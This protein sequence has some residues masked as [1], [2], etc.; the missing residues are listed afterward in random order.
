MNIEIASIREFIIKKARIIWTKGSSWLLPKVKALYAK[1]PKK[2]W[3]AGILLLAYL[4]CLPSPLFKEPTC[5]V[6]E[7]KNGNLLGARIAA[8]GQWRFPYSENIPEKYVQCLVEFED[9]RFYY[10]PG[11]D[12]V[13][14][15]R[16]V[17]QNIRNRK[18]V[19]GGSTI[20]MQVMRMSRKAQSRSL[21]QKLIEAVLA[22]RLEL[23]H[24]KKEIMALYASN[25]PYGG[26]VVGLEAASWRYFGKNPK[27][28]S[29]AEAATLAVLPNSPALIHPGR[30]RESLALK[31]NRLLKRLYDHHKIDKT[32]YSLAIEEPLP[33]QPLPLPRLAPHLLD[34]AYEEYF[35]SEKGKITRLRTTIDPFLQNQVN[36]ILQNHLEHLSGNGI[37]NLAAIVMDVETGNV[38]AYVGNVP[39]AG[40]EHGEDVDVIRAARSTGSI[41]KPFLFSWMLQEGAILP[42]SLVSDIPTELSGYRPENYKETY[43]GAIPARRALSRSLNIPFVRL[44][45]QF[46]LEKFHYR[47]KKVGFSTINKP[48]SYYG[49]P[50][51][52]GGAEATLWDI[53]NAY[54]CMSRVATHYY[55]YEG[56]YDALD[57]HAPNYL[58][59]KRGPRSAGPLRVKDPPFFSASGAW[60]TLDAMQ[61]VERPDADGNWELFQSSKRVAWK[62]GTSFGFRDAWAAGVTPHYAVGVWVG[63]ADGEGRPGL[64]GVEAAAPVLFDIYNVLPTPDWFEQPYDEMV[65]IPVCRQSGFRPIDL[66]ETDTMWVPKAGLKSESCPYH[67]LLHLDAGGRWQVTSDCESPDHM[68]HRPW[69]VLPPVEEY[70][71]KTKNP[72]YQTPP[73]YREDCLKQMGGDKGNPMQL[74]YPRN[75]TKIYVPVDLNGQLSRTVFKVA[76]RVPETTVYWHIDNEFVGS[77]KNFHE[78][79]LIPRSGKHVLTVVDEK[80]FRLQQSFEILEK[81]E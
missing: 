28:L 61:E 41:L 18:V 63:N 43:D 78:I 32:A 53:T 39:G 8:D 37:H 31:R 4:F 65:R 66:C 14:L 68:L 16:A 24:S 9:R 75:L 44:L 22:T 35:R 56:K 48:A 17:V 30:R 12:P 50:L 72:S 7:D 6:L 60:C 47:L 15:A 21:F 40:P 11:V 13:G 42:K 51:I 20:T 77:T 64:V 70:Y 67:Q 71:Y 34:R 3:A 59:G 74:I 57:F 38:L 76:H 55:P 36:I 2:I 49:L 10:H 54:A 62:T 81:T 27:L 23:T 33:D 45:Q 73:P 25:A 19:S 46:G 58:F 26:N 80:G 5:M 79:S 69:F 52:L 1:H 29:W